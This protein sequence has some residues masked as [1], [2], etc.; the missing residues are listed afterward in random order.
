M[1]KMEDVLKLPERVCTICKVSVKKHVG[2]T[3]KYC[4]K[5]VNTEYV[6]DF[7][8]AMS[9][10][11]GNDDSASDVCDQE[12]ELEGHEAV[13]N[14]NEVPAQSDNGHDDNNE[15]SE[16]EKLNETLSAIEQENEILEK[17]LRL[18]ELMKKNNKLKKSIVTVSGGKTLE[19][20][21][22]IKESEQNE[23]LRANKKIAS[24]TMKKENDILAAI[25][26]EPETDDED[27]DDSAGEQ[28]EAI[29]QPL[30]T[31]KLS[32]T[33]FPI[34]TKKLLKDRSKS[35]SSRKASDM[36]LYDVAWPHEYAGSEDIAFTSLSIPAF[37]RGENFIIN[38]IEPEEYRRGRSEHLTLIMSFSEQYPWSDV[39]LYHQDVLHE[40][41]SGRASWCCNHGD[42]DRLKARRLNNT[43][44]KLYCAA[45]NKGN[46]T[47]KVAHQNSFGVLEEHMCSTCW[48]R[49][50]IVRSH[51]AKDCYSSANEPNQARDSR[52]FSN[53]PS[54]G[55]GH[56][57]YPGNSNINPYNRY[58]DGSH[59]Y[60]GNNF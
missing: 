53:R 10:Q 15:Q 25:L 57:S 54:R 26:N 36:A 29:G 37:V 51:P 46:C 23:H 14:D 35:G 44:P 11:T 18:Q 20:K 9:E 2:P 49:Q 30:K 60:P 7:D 16:L 27:P 42:F 58:N 12:L 22:T 55:R 4:S 40:I 38:N 32:Y 43:L 50:R 19:A 3:G 28:L 47:C 59:G 33:V 34:N 21:K 41:E 6:T 48:S 1:W 39:L 8:G 56:A 5:N 31:K 24:E 13:I 17:E 52:D 45:F